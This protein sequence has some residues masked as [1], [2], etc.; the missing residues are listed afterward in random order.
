[1]ERRRERGAVV[2]WVG[3]DSQ[4]PFLYVVSLESRIIGTSL[5]LRDSRE[6]SNIVH[7]GLT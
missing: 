1:M 5:F 4:N 3:S 7:V 2:A 6:A